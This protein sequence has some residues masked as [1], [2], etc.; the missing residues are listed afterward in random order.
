MSELVV[1]KNNKK[2]LIG[3]IAAVVIVVLIFLGI[4]IIAYAVP[5]S[6]YNNE[7]KTAEKYFADLEY[8]QAIAHYIKAVEMRPDNIE[9]YEGIY[10]SYMALADAAVAN[11]DYSAAVGYC[12]E[13]LNILNNGVE[14]V[15]STDM[16]NMISD[17]EARLSEYRK[18]LPFDEYTLLFG[19]RDGQDLEW[20][21][22]DEDSEKM[23]LI[24]K[25]SIDCSGHGQTYCTWEN[26]PV[27]TYLNSD[28]ISE[29]FSEEE[30]ERLIYTDVEVSL[31]TCA[32]MNMEFK[33]AGVTNDRV[34]I[35]SHLEF[36]K[37]F[38]IEGTYI[39]GMRSSSHY[40]MGYPNN[41]EERKRWMEE[42]LIDKS[43][44]IYVDYY[45]AIYPEDVNAYGVNWLL[46][47]VSPEGTEGLTG[48]SEWNIDSIGAT[49]P[50]VFGCAQAVRPVVW[51]K[52]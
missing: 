46:R 11:G 4:F 52:K 3:I 13:A 34:Y 40:A 47:D 14:Y 17:V 22:L 23:L 21:I 35:L 12:N 8:E 29:T 7:I 41:S 19:Q 24:T 51:I 20:I 45:A 44:W 48:E 5:T 10:E 15:A 18:N 6:K 39:N 43:E 42:R 32:N 31:I 38:P 1:K 2:V 49:H 28:F 50:F 30:E 25:Y 37:Y 9:A 26:S 36:E 16:D 27:R 33:T